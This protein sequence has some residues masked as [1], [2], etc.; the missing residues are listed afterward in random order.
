M[1]CRIFLIAPTELLQIIWDL[2][3]LAFFFLLRIGEYTPSKDPRRTIP[4]HKKDVRLWLN[5]QFISHD[6]P[7][8]ELLAAD[9]VTPCL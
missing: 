5:N 8:V 3:V 2:V 6:V 4:L 9:A 1:D 7:L